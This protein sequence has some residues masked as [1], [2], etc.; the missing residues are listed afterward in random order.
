MM[1]AYP[2]NAQYEELQMIE[3]QTV[4]I[5]LTPKEQQC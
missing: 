2:V 3:E 1:H 5:R 4:L